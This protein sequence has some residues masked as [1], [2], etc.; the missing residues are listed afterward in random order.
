[1][2][3]MRSLEESHLSKSDLNENPI[4]NKVEFYSESVKIHIDSPDQEKL[5]AGN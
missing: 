3:K 2:I 5:T 4:E 1:M